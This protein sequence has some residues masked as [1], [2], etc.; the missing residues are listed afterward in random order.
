MNLRLFADLPLR[1]VFQNFPR[2]VSG[3]SISRFDRKVF[4]IA[5]RYTPFRLECV[6]SGKLMSPGASLTD[7]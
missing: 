1:E 7:E 6:A 5:K 4:S 3:L 2:S